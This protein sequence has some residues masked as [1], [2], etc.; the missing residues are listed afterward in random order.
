MKYNACSIITFIAAALLLGAILE[1]ISSPTIVIYLSGAVLGF[2]WMMV[3][4]LF[5]IK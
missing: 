3:W 5:K 2:L 1:S 4:P